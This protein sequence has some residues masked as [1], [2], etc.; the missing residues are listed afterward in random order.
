MRLFRKSQLENLAVTMAG[1]KLGDRMLVLGCGD[2]QLIAALALK[3]GL[4]GR[5]CAV[6]ESAERA[7]EAGRVANAEGALIETFTAPFSKLPLDDASFD[8]VVL[9]D[10]LVETPA[11]NR[12]RLA[13]EVWR[14]LR[15][16]G[17][18][19]A[20]ESSTRRGGLSGI[21]RSGA[22]RVDTAG[23]TKALEEAAFRGV[24]T[25]A[26]RERLVFV[27]AVKAAASGGL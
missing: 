12:I 15:P 26:E 5:A 25:L 20:I 8:L 22:T 7:A 4:T 3:T 11:E 1:A 21:W 9:R 14:V 16:G 24:R 2:P 17:R 18:C 13:Q 27:E 23:A 19:V 10:V 6:D